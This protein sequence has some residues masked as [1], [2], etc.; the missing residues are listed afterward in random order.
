MNTKPQC[1]QCN[2]FNEGS[3][4]IF[5]ERLIAEYGEGKVANMEIKKST[6]K[7]HDYD[8]LVISL[9]KEL[10][11]FLKDKE[12]EFIDALIPESRR[13]IVKS[14]DKNNN[15]DEQNLQ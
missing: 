4:G 2:S 3:G 1:M 9:K 14:K 7:I 8:K 15:H 5:R 6:K 13:Y 12:K 10:N 11:N